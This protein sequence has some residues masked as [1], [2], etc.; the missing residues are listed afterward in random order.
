MTTLIINWIS[1]NA[2][3]ESSSAIEEVKVDVDSCETLN[4]VFQCVLRHKLLM[5][6]DAKQ[7]VFFLW[8]VHQSKAIP[9]YNSQ[10]FS[11]TNAFNTISKVYDIA[12]EDTITSYMD[13]D[14]DDDDNQSIE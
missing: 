13:E 11:V 5:F 6:E 7:F 14:E 12:F 2:N 1:N 3:F 8:A 10:K 9:K 4:D